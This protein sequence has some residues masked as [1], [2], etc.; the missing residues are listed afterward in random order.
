[1]ILL[2]APAL[3]Q[4]GLDDVKRA[5]CALGILPAGMAAPRQAPPAPP[6]TPET[7]DN[8]AESVRALAQGPNS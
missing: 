4:I 8:P 7:G 6:A 3:E 1:M 2:H 5:A